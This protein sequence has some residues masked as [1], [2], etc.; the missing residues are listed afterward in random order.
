MEAVEENW[1][2]SGEQTAKAA[3]T[4]ELRNCRNLREAEHGNG[5][6]KRW[7]E[8]FNEAGLGRRQGDQS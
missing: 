3:D 4:E 7:L 2:G 5:G 6:T 1:R 8:P